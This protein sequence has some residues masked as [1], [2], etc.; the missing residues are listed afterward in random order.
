MTFKM[1]IDDAW[2]VWHA[3]EALIKIKGTAEGPAIL[4]SL[5][6]LLLRELKPQKLARRLRQFLEGA[7]AHALRREFETFLHSHHSN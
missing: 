4:S 2:G 5:L 3:L 6:R 7:D 1:K